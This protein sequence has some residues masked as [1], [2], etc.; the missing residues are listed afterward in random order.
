MIGTFIVMLALVHHPSCIVRTRHLPGL[1]SFDTTRIAEIMG[2]LPNG[3]G[4]FHFA[5][6]ID[7]LE[8]IADLV[9]P[10]LARCRH[11]AEAAR[12]MQRPWLRFMPAFL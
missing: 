8:D 2:R 9:A 1:A 7:A 6:P 3:L 5:E 11:A 4:A 12:V 10:I